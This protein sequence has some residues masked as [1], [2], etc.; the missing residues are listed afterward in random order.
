MGWRVAQQYSFAK[1]GDGFDN[2]QVKY[3]SIALNI[4]IY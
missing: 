2:T 4:K 1:V 3:A